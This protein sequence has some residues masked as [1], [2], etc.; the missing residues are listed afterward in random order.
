MLIICVVMKREAKIIVSS[1]HPN[2]RLGDEDAF[3]N[4]LKVVIELL[5]NNLSGK[6]Y[7]HT[8]PISNAKQL[9]SHCYV[10]I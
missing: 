5:R 8:V 10:L 1:I 4:S 2:Y 6:Y 7:H 3:Q 9:C